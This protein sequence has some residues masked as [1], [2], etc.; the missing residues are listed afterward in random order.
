MVFR[1]AA[2]V[3]MKTREAGT[4]MY[5]RDRKRVESLAEIAKKKHTLALR[6][7]FLAVSPYDMNVRSLRGFAVKIVLYAKSI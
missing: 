3:M 5:E 7:H 1:Q 6:I 2:A 4:I